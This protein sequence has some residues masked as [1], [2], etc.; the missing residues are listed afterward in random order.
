MFVHNRWL[1]QTG[2][3]IQE[4]SQELVS[5]LV[6]YD[7][8]YVIVTG[9]RFAVIDRKTYVRKS[10]ETNRAVFD[11]L[12]VQFGQDQIINLNNTGIYIIEGATRLR[13]DGVEFRAMNVTSFG[14]KFNRSSPIGITEVK[15]RRITP[16]AD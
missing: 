14:Q 4:N 6:S 12:T 13:Y 2:T 5:G 10:D 9:T 15:F 8:P 11:D 7:T 3:I 1:E 16:L